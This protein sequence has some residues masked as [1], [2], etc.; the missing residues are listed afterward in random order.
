[1]PN[2]DD[3]KYS[4]L[5]WELSTLCMASIC[6]PIYLQNNISY[7]RVPI[8]NTM[9]FLGDGDGQTLRSESHWLTMRPLFFLPAMASDHSSMIYKLELLKNCWVHNLLAM[10]LSAQTYWQWAWPKFYPLLSTHHVIGTHFLT[11]ESDKH[12]R[13]LTRLY[14]TITWKAVGM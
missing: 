13:L 4:P 10:C 6:L 2:K 9:M 11:T 7:T 8:L 14:G 5:D 3:I 1:M 12:M